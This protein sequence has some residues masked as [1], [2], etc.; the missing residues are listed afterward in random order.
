MTKKRYIKPSFFSWPA[1]SYYGELSILRIK[2]ENTKDA[3]EADLV[4][5]IMVMFLLWWIEFNDAQG[6]Q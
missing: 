1:T 3:I 6:E 5:S 2:V 4:K